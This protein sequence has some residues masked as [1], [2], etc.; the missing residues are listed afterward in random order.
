[1]RG[2]FIVIEG[3]DGAGKKT[4][5]QLLAERL[6]AGGRRVETISFPRYGQTSASLVERYLRGEIGPKEAVSPEVSSALYAHDR[7]AAAPQIEAWLAAG[8]I[9]L[10]DRYTQSNMAHQ[11]AKIA[12]AEK[13]A[14]LLSWL[15]DLEFVRLGIPRPDLTLVLAVPSAFRDA[16]V[17]KKEARAYLKGKAKDIHEGDVAYQE[18]VEAVY[19]E[20]AQALPKH[21]WIDCTEGGVLIGA[22]RCHDLV[23][24]HVAAILP[25]RT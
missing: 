4:Q 11:G 7:A 3:G 9:V 20:I 1:M 22:N 2:I 21:V 6:R 24:P 19:K 18:R 13:R 16:N 14:V 5:T 8:A 17:G 25:P 15:D 12:E 10:S 23:W